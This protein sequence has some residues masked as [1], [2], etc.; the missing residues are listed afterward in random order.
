[1]V[2]IPIVHSGYLFLSSLAIGN[3]RRD[4]TFR[5]VADRLTTLMS[6]S[7]SA[8][9][10]STEKIN[11][12]RKFV[13]AAL[14]SI[15]IVSIVQAAFTFF[16]GNSIANICEANNSNTPYCEAG[17]KTRPLLQ[18][19]AF[20]FWLT[21]TTIIATAGSILVKCV[22]KENRIPIEWIMLYAFTIGYLITVSWTIFQPAALNNTEDINERLN[23]VVLS[24]VIL[25]FVLF[26]RSI[27][28]YYIG[29]GIYFP[30]M[31][32]KK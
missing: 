14:V 10:H 27:L 11:G 3:I 12:T 21:I 15:F 17:E 1:V 18:S 28:D 26:V 23:T 5:E 29:Q 22:I 6:R 13:P 7:E 32:E 20:V 9:M 31:F 4:L 16:L 8:R 2:A 24:S 30:E 25:L 19:N